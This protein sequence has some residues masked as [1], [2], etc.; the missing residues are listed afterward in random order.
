[1]LRT[2][3]LLLATLL[4]AHSGRW[5]TATCTEGVVSV[6]RGGRAEMGCRIANAF[7]HVSILL[8]V[9]GSHCQTVFSEEGPGN[10]SRGGWRLQ[11]QGG[12]AQLVI[13][14]ARTSQ[15]GTYKWRLAGLQR[16]VRFTTLNVS[17][18]QAPED[19]P[20]ESGGPPRPHAG[21]GGA[22]RPAPGPAGGRG[23]PGLGGGGARG[24]RSPGALLAVVS[25]R[26]DARADVEAEPAEPRA[27]GAPQQT[28]P[29]RAHP[30]EC[31]EG[32]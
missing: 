19:A 2:L 24:R 27:G 26:L 16:N 17:E 9:H 4:R 14:D 30:V 6:P 32:L 5:D 28:P 20:E 1:M 31:D 23:A 12:L 10:F 15:A 7:S 8:C 3:L 22:A 11:V 21:R 25:R 18:P 29:G 13:E